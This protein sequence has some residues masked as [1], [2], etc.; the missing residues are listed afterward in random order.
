MSNDRSYLCLCAS[1]HPL[2]RYGPQLH[3]LLR[4]QLVLRLRVALD[5][6]QLAALGANRV[7]R[8]TME[9]FPWLW[10]PHLPPLILVVRHSVIIPRRLLTLVQIRSPRQLFA[11]LPLLPRRRAHGLDRPSAAARPCTPDLVPE[12]LVPPFERVER[13][14]SSRRR[15]LL[16]HGGRRG[17]RG[18]TR[19]SSKCFL[20]SAS[21]SARSCRLDLCCAREL[22]AQEW[23]RGP[24]EG[25]RERRR[26]WWRLRGREQ[27]CWRRRMARGRRER[28]WSTPAAAILPTT[29]LCA[30]Q[31]CA[32]PSSVNGLRPFLRV[33]LPSQIYLLDDRELS[34]FLPRVNRLPTTSSN[35]R[36]VRERRRRLVAAEHGVRD[37]ERA[38]GWIEHGLCDGGDC[39]ASRGQRGDCGC[40]CGEKQ[41]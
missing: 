12:A 35:A 27:R 16:L 28:L 30:Q 29:D 3:V 5:Q 41:T 39:S 17:R 26:L 8:I 33:C 31:L 40:C 10:F 19:A 34:Q 13:R 20:A 14:R 18:I 38:R 6:V 24:Q 22:P 32:T 36:S 25:R 21:P 7:S 4:R 37:A 23:E 9:L 15:L 1:L 2:R 11:L